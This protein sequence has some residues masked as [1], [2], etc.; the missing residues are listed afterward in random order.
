MTIEA[1]SPEVAGDQ[2][3]V[4]VKGWLLRADEKLLW[5][6][7]PEIVRFL[8]Q[9]LSFSLPAF[10]V[11]PSIV[12]FIY[13]FRE[14]FIQSELLQAALFFSVAGALFQF[15]RTLWDCRRTFY[16]LTDQ[17]ALIEIGVDTRSIP[18][19]DVQSIR[20]R[21]SKNGLGDVV[22]GEVRVAN[23]EDQWITE[24]GFIAIRDAAG[25][26]HLVRGL[27]EKYAAKSI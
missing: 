4:V 9:R 2:Q 12:A 13:F 21:A 14:G 19:R 5:S 7:R 26:E 15:G 17:R 22:L 10:L 20:V 24:E 25:V 27:M 23:G 11:I 3:H 1:N 18:I 16:A 8:R 6:G